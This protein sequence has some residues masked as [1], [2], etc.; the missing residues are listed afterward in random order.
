MLYLHVI[1]ENYKKPISSQKYIEEGRMA[2]VPGFLYQQRHLHKVA[3][4]KINLTQ[5]V[6]V[7]VVWR[8]LWIF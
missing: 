4:V 6:V 2:L 3:I 1:I 7:S 8:L 5:A